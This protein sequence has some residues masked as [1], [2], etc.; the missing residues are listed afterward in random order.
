MWWHKNFKI[1]HFLKKDKQLLIF[2]PAPAINITWYVYANKNIINTYYTKGPVKGYG[3]LK[4]KKISESKTEVYYNI[5]VSPRT[6]LIKTILSLLLQAFKRVHVFHIKQ[7]FKSLE[8]H[9][10]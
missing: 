6:N 4:T 3:A 9:L 7:L 10:N 8:K 2:S 1:K 5:L